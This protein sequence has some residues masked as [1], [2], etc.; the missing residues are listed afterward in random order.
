MVLEIAP[1]TIFSQNSS[2]RFTIAL[3]LVLAAGTTLFDERSA[4]SS[5]R[6]LS[7]G[8]VLVSIG[9]AVLRSRGST[10]FRDAR[11]ADCARG[12]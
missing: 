11:S 2:G 6:S 3:P 7:S 1:H 12:V 9:L 4:S 5:L 8:S 10:S